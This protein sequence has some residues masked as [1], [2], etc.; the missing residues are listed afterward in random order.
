MGSFDKKKNMAIRWMSL[1]NTVLKAETRY[2]CY[3]EMQCTRIWVENIT[4][5]MCHENGE[6]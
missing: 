6:I 1:C 5:V 4:V 3:N 2:L